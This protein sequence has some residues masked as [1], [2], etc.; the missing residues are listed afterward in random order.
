MD[1]AGKLQSIAIFINKNGPVAALKKMADSP[2]PPIKIIRITRIQ[3]MNDAM[4]ISSGRLQEK[5]V[6]VGHQ[7]K[8][9]DLRP[10]SF[11]SG[12][13]IAE[14]PLII[15]VDSEDGSSLIPSG[16]DVI[17]GTRVLNS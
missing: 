12:F 17:E 7:A 1:V 13:K 3:M 8:A 16:S 10:I 11:G 2:G 9:M 6:V 15:S 14:E 4:K 5:M